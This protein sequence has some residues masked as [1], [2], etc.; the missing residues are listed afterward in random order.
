MVSTN[1]IGSMRDFIVNNNTIKTAPIASRFTFIISAVM[2]GG[3]C[4]GV[5]L[6]HINH[7]ALIGSD[8]DHL[9]D[10]AAS[11][12]IVLILDEPAL[13]ADRKLVDESGSTVSALL[14]VR[15]LRANL[16]VTLLPDST[17]K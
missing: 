9:A 12:F 4:D 1:I 8:I 14:A 5:D 7:N 11:V 2:V 10:N 6:R 13:Q 3:K 17:P 15:P 16:S